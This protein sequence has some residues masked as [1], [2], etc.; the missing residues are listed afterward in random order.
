MEQGVKLSDTI[1]VIRE[2]TSSLMQEIMT[3]VSRGCTLDPNEMSYGYVYSGVDDA[4]VETRVLHLK[5]SEGTL[6]VFMVPYGDGSD[7][8]EEESLGFWPD[9]DISFL[10]RWYAVDESFYGLT[11]PTLISIA[12]GL[13]INKNNNQ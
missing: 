8:S 12:E 9:S 3:L 2:T 11:V 6:Y 1:K 10:P 4:V 13:M 5:V 7:Y